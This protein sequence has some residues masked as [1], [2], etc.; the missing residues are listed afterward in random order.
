MVKPAQFLTPLRLEKTGERSWLVLEPFKF[1]SAE[2]G[3]TFVVPAGT[4]TDLASIP[5]LLWAIF[6]KIGR[7]DAASV[8]H[9]AGYS[10]VLIDSLGYSLRP[11][12]KTCDRLFLEGMLASG[13]PSR[14]AHEMYYA[15]KMFGHTHVGTAS[16]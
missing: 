4:P 2:N 15:V 16:V 11:D 10:G 14:K 13:V 3:R 1:Y 6:P 9:D 8:I 12:K 5:R 7:Q